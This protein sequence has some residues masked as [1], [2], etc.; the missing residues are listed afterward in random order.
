MDT[1]NDD[2]QRY[3]FKILSI[4][5]KRMIIRTCKH[6][7][8]FQ[9]RMPDAELFFQEMINDTSFISDKFFGGFHNSL[10]KYTIE[11]LYD[12]YQLPDKY[13][14]L[15]NVIIYQHPKIYYKF[16]EQN[17]ILTVK[18][19]IKLPI[20]LSVCMTHIAN[21][22]AKIG[23]IDILEHISTKYSLD[24]R[25]YTFAI[26]GNQLEILK[27]LVK[28]ISVSE[29]SIIRCAI[30]EGSIDIVNYFMRQ[31]YYSDD[32]DFGYHA[33][34]SGNIDMINLFE[35]TYPVF[36]KDIGRGIIRGDDFDLFK[37]A[38][39]KRWISDLTIN[40]I[41]TGQIYYPCKNIKMLS[42]FINNNYIRYDVSESVVTY[43]NLEC[44]HFLHSKGMLVLSK[45]MF[46][47]AIYS[48]DT[49]I[50][51]F[52]HSLGCPK[53]DLTIDIFVQVFYEKKGHRKQSNEIWIGI[54]LLEEWGY[55]WGDICTTAAT[56]G[57]IEILKYAHKSGCPL[58]A[59]VINSAAHHGYLHIIIW[60]REHGCKW[61]TSTCKNSIDGYNFDILKWLI[62]YKNFRSTCSLASNE[63]EICPWDVQKCRYLSNYDFI[64][65]AI[66]NSNE[67]YGTF[68]IEDIND[69]F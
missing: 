36:L 35:S 42:W 50:M 5:A 58:T 63:T 37:I 21:H 34:V 48:C 31:N 10:S 24:T 6:L 69:Y 32:Y 14:T 20:N 47:L 29:S 27:W 17:D 59:D 46:E 41:I 7:R 13:I 3:L 11:L 15:K 8:R 4:S 68:K 30:T 61:N 1:L 2:T 66:E 55:K 49:D 65:S 38:L 39:D 45:R 26:K 18:K 56:H 9:D 44:L 62:N 40:M 43:G 23:N 52:L 12:D 64:K 22:A 57:D 33:G 67:N 16:V 51:Q 60:L 54:K 53:C 25:I 28:H 19:I